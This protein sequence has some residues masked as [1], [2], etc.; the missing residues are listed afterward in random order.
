M[1]MRRQ[2]VSLGA[3]FVVAA[4]LALTLSS[5]PALATGD[6]NVAGCPNEA[7]T[8]FTP[9]LPD[10]RA[11]ELVS[12]PY[13]EG[14]EAQAGTAELS[15]DGSRAVFRDVGA[16][17]GVGNGS[18]FGSPMYEMERAGAGWQTVAALN[19]LAEQYPYS[20]I[21]GVSGDLRRSLWLAIPAAQYT[22]LHEGRTPENELVLR[23]AQPGGGVG[24]VDVG[25]LAAAV[26]ETESGKTVL[27]SPELGASADLTHVV[28]GVQVSGA[29]KRFIWP[30]DATVSGLSLYEYAGAEHHARPALVGVEDAGALISQCGTALGGYV[31]T[32]NEKRVGEASATSMYNAVSAGGERV[33]FTAEQG[34]CSGKDETGTT[35]TGTGPTARELYV[36]V[37]GA[38]T[39]AISEPTTGDCELCN[40][41]SPVA[42]VF[43]GASED[44]SK[45]F[46]TTTQKLLPADTDT[47]TDLYEYDF[48]APAGKKVVM[49][50]AGEANAGTPGAEKAEALGVARISQDGS[51]VYFVAQGV[52]TTKPDESLPSGHQVAAAGEDNLYVYDALTE[53]TAFVATLSPSDSADWQAEDHRPVQANGCLPPAPAGCEAGRFLVFGSVEKL[54]AGDTS[55]VS[56]I[57]EYD[58]QT[59]ALVRVSI[60]QGGYNS[61]GN[62]TVAAYAP[63]IP[64]PPYAGSSVDSMTA[65]TVAATE[66]SLALSDDGAYA[67][68]QSADG[69]TPR[70]ANGVP[71]GEKGGE[72]VYAQNVYEYHAGSVYLLSDGMD[73]TAG[74]EGSNV[75]F[76]GTD[77]SGADAL[78]TTADRLAPQDTDTQVDLYDAHI[79]GGFPPPAL[80]GCEGEGC[81][82]R[83][84]VESYPPTAGGSAVQAGGGNLGPPVESKPAVKPKSKPL[85]SAQKLAKALKAC[86]KRPKKQRAACKRQARKRYAGKAKATKS[87]K[88]RGRS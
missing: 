13:K 23:E 85:T 79:G 32:I 16:F 59:E 28:F 62:T 44:G 80:G 56:Q 4:G 57:F 52:L 77:G 65:S 30:G 53:E 6:A 41:S 12:P 64:S 15:S 31:G 54:T 88:G 39:V 17:E 27:D 50:S 37:G 19:P 21:L 5:S 33:F 1:Y 45:V 11:Y 18:L 35:V 68:F 81:Q 34:G 48:N 3:S 74:I 38:K 86:G 66:G 9:S 10:C 51:H 26:D 82:G 36:R 61:D 55:T 8:G 22:G 46:F 87:A 2:Q 47:S 7:M 60:G 58:A 67:F 49:V 70:A 43:Q 84:G 76:V 14:F 40:T 25:P 83:L 29:D 72:P 75:Q 63:K 24:T 42:A 69:L 73:L 20:D 71:L 78:F